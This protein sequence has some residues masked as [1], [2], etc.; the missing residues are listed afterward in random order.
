MNHQF[1]KEKKPDVTAAYK[2]VTMR[3][4]FYKSI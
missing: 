1:S 2:A 3:V 4:V